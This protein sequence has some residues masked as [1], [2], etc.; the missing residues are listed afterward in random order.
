MDAGLASLL[1]ETAF[2]HH[3]EPS[4]VYQRHRVGTMLKY[5]PGE[6]IAKTAFTHRQD[7]G[8]IIY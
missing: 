4:G 6:L 8:H 7:R 1:A 3:A 2:M 5:S